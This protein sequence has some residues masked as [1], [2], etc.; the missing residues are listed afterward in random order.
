MTSKELTNKIEASKAEGHSV[1]AVDL[2]GRKYIYRSINR[3][4]FR[5][6]QADT[7]R[8]QTDIV[9]S[10]ASDAE[11][12]IKIAGLGDTS[13]EELVVVAVLDPPFDTTM[14][15][16]NVPAGVITSLTNLIMSAS[17]FG[18]EAKPTAL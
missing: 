15:L 13:E 18:A 12:E 1:F 14:D 6:L 3:N 4:E 17:A 11:K 2:A 5:K 9:N 8:R 10:T 16:V 7:A